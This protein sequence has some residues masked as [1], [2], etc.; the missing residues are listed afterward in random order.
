MFFFN[1]L[2]CCCNRKP[3]CVRCEDKRDCDRHNNCCRCESKRDC[4]GHNNN[5]C[6]CRCCCHREAR[7]VRPHCCCRCRCTHMCGHDNNMD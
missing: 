6:R 5:C 2:S 3:Q 7:P 1:N 4:D